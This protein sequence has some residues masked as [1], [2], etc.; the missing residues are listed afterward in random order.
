MRQLEGMGVN[1][2]PFRKK[3]N[4]QLKAEKTKVG[5]REIIELKA[6]ISQCNGL[7]SF[8]KQSFILSQSPI[9]CVGL[10]LET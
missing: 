9:R 7:K 4:E 10:F 8:Q 6:E 2:I 1:L 5:L 3:L